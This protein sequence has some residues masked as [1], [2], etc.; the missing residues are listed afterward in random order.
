M[1]AHNDKMLWDMNFIRLVQD[2]EVDYVS[3]FFNALYSI[4]MGRIG[5]DKLS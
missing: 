5:E 2:W 1:S 4:R 3:S